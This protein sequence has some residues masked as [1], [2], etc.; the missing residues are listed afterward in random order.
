MRSRGRG[1]RRRRRPMSGY[2]TPS[3]RMSGATACQPLPVDAP[4]PRGAD[5]RAGSPDFCSVIYASTLMRGSGSAV[6]SRTTER[7]LKG[8]ATLG[9]RM[10]CSLTA[11]A[12]AVPVGPGCVAVSTKLHRVEVTTEPPGAYVWREVDGDRRTIGQA[13]L[14]VE[15]EYQAHNHE[16]NSA[17]WLW[18]LPAAGATGAGI[19]L[20]T[21]GSDD[22]S[23]TSG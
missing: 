12:L 20:A 17:N 16:F 22:G 23:S 6:A 9:R 18:L 10:L 4:R 5:R 3:S 1:C 15:T 14:V 19:Y 8:R 2:P 7:R 13:P 11:A 21:G